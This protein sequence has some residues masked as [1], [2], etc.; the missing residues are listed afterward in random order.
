MLN[1]NSVTDPASIGKI[2]AALETASVDSDY[3]TGLAGLQG[4]L[5]LFHVQSGSLPKRVMIDIKP[6]SDP[7]PINPRAAGVIP[8]ALLCS[9]TFDATSVD[10]TSVRFG[11]GQATP[12][13]GAHIQDVNGDG[14]PDMVFQFSTQGSQIACTDTAVF[15]MGKTMSGGTIVGSDQ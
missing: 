8:V 13:R 9:T 14:R 6:D 3:F 11:P 4:L 5:T 2:K 12:S 7:A 1:T 10:P 15:L